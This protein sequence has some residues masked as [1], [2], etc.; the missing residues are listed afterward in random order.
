MN[1]GYGKFNDKVRNQIC[2]MCGKDIYVHKY[3]RN[4]ACVNIDCPLGHEAKELVEK[5]NKIIYMIN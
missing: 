2:P 1:I 3:G 5:I 4:F